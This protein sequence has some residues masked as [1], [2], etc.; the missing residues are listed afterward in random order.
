MLTYREWKAKKRL[1]EMFPPPG[2][3]PNAPMQQGSGG[4]VTAQIQGLEQQLN[5]PRTPMQAK[6]EIRTK[7]RQLS[8]GQ[9]PVNPNTPR[10]NTPAPLS[11]YQWINGRPVPPNG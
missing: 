6:V 7:L 5:D 9:T 1:I 11:N 10:P 3:A 8:Q 4:D 2:T